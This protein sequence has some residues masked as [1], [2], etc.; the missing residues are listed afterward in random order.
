MDRMREE[1]SA[2]AG[3]T[4]LAAV[5]AALSAHSAKHKHLLSRSRDD[6]RLCY[7]DC[8]DEGLP[9]RLALA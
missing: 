9:F 1:I 6:H 3:V 2:V 8:A 5:L 4:V 7:F